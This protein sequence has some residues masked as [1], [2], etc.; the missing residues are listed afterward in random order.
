MT[1]V[2]S[3]DSPSSQSPT[4]QRSKSGSKSTH[5]R[6]VQEIPTGYGHNDVDGDGNLAKVLQSDDQS[7]SVYIQELQKTIDVLRAKQEGHQ[8]R[9]AQGRRSHISGEGDEHHRSA[10]SGEDRIHS[11]HFQNGEENEKG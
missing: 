5:S 10:H 2:D 1:S 3:D 4:T 9:S 11:G 8:D 7:L 6:R